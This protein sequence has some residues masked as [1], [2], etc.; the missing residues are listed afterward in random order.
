MSDINENNKNEKDEKETK[1]ENLC[2]LYLKL[3][4]F[5][6]GRKDLKTFDDEK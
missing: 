5:S 1:E 4:A 3:C 6:A 2:S